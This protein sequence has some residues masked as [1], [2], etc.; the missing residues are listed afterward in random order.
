[1]CHTSVT[2]R[3]NLLT[4]CEQQCYRYCCSRCKPSSPKS[5]YH[6]SCISLIGPLAPS[7]D[8]LCY[9]LFES[10]C[11]LSTTSKYCLLQN[12]FPV[13]ELVAG[14]DLHCNSYITQSA[15]PCILCITS[16]L[17]NYMISIFHN[18]KTVA[19]LSCVCPRGSRHVNK[20]ASYQLGAWGPRQTQQLSP[21][22]A[23]AFWFMHLMSSFDSVQF[24]PQQAHHRYCCASCT[25][26]ATSC[27][28]RSAAPV[29]C[30]VAAHLVSA[31]L[32]SI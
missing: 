4:V 13:S 12:L 19:A 10:A 15:T 16:Q 28:C 14:S 2:N 31:S 7:P 18:D 30:F 32:R 11:A 3:A 5:G 24:T 17:V 20:L 29:S 22:V 9:F 1:M 8:T 6:I 21:A 25:E 23:H 26:S 27:S